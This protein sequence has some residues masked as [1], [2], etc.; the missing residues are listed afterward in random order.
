MI[1]VIINQLTKIVYNKLVKFIINALGLIKVIFNV[2]V[3][4]PG[5]QNYIISNQGLVFTLKFLL[6][7]YQ[8]F[9]IKSQ[10]FI[11]FYLQTN[12]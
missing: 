3:R 11:T 4:Q 7:L 5:I 6:F 10:F 9:S 1:L 8:F 2:V 12:S